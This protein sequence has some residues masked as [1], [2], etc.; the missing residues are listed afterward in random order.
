M[1]NRI[2]SFD[3][4]KGIAIILMIV[5]HT[6]GPNYIIWNFIYSFHMPLFF[7]V[8]GYFYKP[9]Q[10]SKLLK[11][12]CVQLLVPYL[13]MCC[14]IAFLTQMRQQHNISGDFESTLNGL[15]PGWFLLAMFMARIEFH[16][17]L[18]YF[19][20]HYLS[21]SLIISTTICLSSS[22]TGIST[23][24]SFYPSLASLLFLATGYYI[25]QY[26]LKKVLDNK[27]CIFIPLGFVLWLITSIYGKVDL[28]LCFF[29]LS[30]I[31]FAGSLGGTYI[32][33]TVSQH[34][35]KYNYFIKTFLSFA[36]KYSLIILF[37]HSI[38]YCV[39]VWY[40]ISS[41]ISQEILLHV[42]LIIRI[43]LVV[44]CVIVTINTKW[45]RCFFNINR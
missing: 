39:P 19:P 32:F 22:Y 10:L 29:K 31:D 7:I 1:T 12:N 33:Y 21:L 38:D 37:Y 41:H 11:N 26:Q 28:S 5:A 36:G 6:Y 34:I 3:I 4:L 27:T 20:H 40:I 9:K 15:G 43:M 45:G 25:K 42:I 24:L 35:N 44:L 16:F 8:S 2:E 23:I 13:T 17:I 18:K 14:V 30:I